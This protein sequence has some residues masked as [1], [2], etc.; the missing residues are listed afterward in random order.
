MAGYRARIAQGFSACSGRWS[1]H[2]LGLKAVMWLW[3][4]SEAVRHLSGGTAR[5]VVHHGTFCLTLLVP[6][7]E[8][9]FIICNIQEL[10]TNR[11]E[12]SI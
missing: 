3:Y 6:Y 7:T 4:R 2:V 5:L 9:Y 8:L 11:T 12:G 1:G 10:G